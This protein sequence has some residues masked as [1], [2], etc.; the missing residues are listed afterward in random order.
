MF[1]DVVSAN[2]IASLLQGEIDERKRERER[3]NRVLTQRVLPVAF[4]VS[5]AIVVGEFA[6][7]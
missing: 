7:V 1:I 6:K 2:T 4:V 5:C 3:G